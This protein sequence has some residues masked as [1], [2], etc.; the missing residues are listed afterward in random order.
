M[1]QRKIVGD[2]AWDNRMSPIL[3]GI[4]GYIDTAY[5]T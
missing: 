4:I 1:N 3:V 2:I 5:K